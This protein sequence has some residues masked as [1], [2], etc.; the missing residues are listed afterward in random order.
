MRTQGVA[1][2]IEIPNKANALGR[3]K[4]PLRFAFYRW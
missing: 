4:A 2:K 1:M 3:Q